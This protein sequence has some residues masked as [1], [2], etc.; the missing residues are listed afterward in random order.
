MN[1]KDQFVIYLNKLTLRSHQV[2]S[3]TASSLYS[4][5]T[6]VYTLQVSIWYFNID[7]DRYRITI[8]YEAYYSLDLAPSDFYLNYLLI[9]WVGK[10]WKNAKSH[11]NFVQEKMFESWKDGYR[12]L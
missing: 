5:W 10:N 12:K 2:N 3:C 11:R 4:E 6:Y 1:I 9:L 7:E 8:V